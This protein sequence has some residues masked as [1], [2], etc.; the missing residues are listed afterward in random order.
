MSL[1]GSE[2]RQK[3]TSYF[4]EKRGH[5]H[6][7]SA[8]LIPDNKTLLLTSAGMVPFVPYFLGQAPPPASRITT[9]QKS[10]APAEKIR[11]LRT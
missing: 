3:F 4:K 10:R 2:I 11:I 8:S 1:S 5:L 7:P 6:L 9:C